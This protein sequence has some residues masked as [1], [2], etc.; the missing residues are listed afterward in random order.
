[1]PADA[2]HGADGGVVTCEEGEEIGSSV[3]GGCW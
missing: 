2:C 3:V 1:L